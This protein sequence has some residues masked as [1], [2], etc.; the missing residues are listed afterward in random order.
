MLRIILLGV[1]GIISGVIGGM[2]MGG[3]TLLIPC[4]T[5]LF[6]ISQ[7]VAQTINLLSFVPMAIVSVIVHKKNGLIKKEGILFIII[8]AIIAA[9]VFSIISQNIEGMLLS[10]IFGGF[11][12]ALAIVQAVVPF[13][14]EKK[15]KDKKVK[16]RK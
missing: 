13:V 5:M 15:A 12:I 2:G 7:H 11:L 3:G 14:L 8:P 1:C 6:D 4:L 9:I 10:R 16:T